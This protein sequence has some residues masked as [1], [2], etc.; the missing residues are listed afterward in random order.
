MAG[1]YI[2]VPFCKRKCSYCDF[3][4]VTAQNKIPVFIN[5]I[6]REI[7]LKK[8][9]P[10]GNITFDTVYFGG[11]T[12]SLLSS[13]QISEILT[14]VY[15]NFTVSNDP[16]ITIEANPFTLDNNNLE[17][18]RKTG[19]NRISIGCQSFNNDELKLLGRLHNSNQGENAVKLA[20]EFFDN[21]SID[22]IFGLPGQSKETWR[23]TLNKATA[24]K[25]D[26]ISTYVLSWSDRTPMGRLIET[27]RLEKP[28]TETIAEM[29]LMTSSMLKSA[30]YIHYEI[31]NFAQPGMESKHNTGYWN[32]EPYL[33]FGP[34]AHSFSG[35]MREW[36]ASNID[37][38]VSMISHGEK[39]VQDCEELSENDRLLERIALGLRTVKGIPLSIIKNSLDIAEYLVKKGLARKEGNRFILLPEGMLLADEIAVKFIQLCQ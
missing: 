11:G 32:G 26:H 13:L 2:H 9:S 37:E 33:G 35:S 1:I 6:I 10:F 38:Y 7:F 18:F 36:N 5:S 14:A 22:L 8:E 15:N 19:I 17:N 27:G 29:Y 16:E 28:E 21:I 31:S 39:P 3:Y 20:K 4:S 23:K 12:P 30:G 24:L 25:P 34:S